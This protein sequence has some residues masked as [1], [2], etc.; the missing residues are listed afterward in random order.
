MGNNSIDHYYKIISIIE[1]NPD[2]TQ[3]KIAKELGYS[4]GKVNYVIASLAQK[5]IIKLQRFVQSK[6]KL[7]YRYILTPEGIKQKYNITKAFL[8]MKMDE[9]DSIV[10]EIEGARDVLNNGES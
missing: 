10:K 3:R 7:V 8:K 9:Y 5:G 1:K 2:Y 4:L 6:N